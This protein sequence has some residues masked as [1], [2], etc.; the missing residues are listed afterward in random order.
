MVKFTPQTGAFMLPV[1][2]FIERCAS[3]SDAAAVICGPAS[4]VV[5]EWVVWVPVLLFIVD[6]FLKRSYP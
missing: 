5:V 1:F 4:N 2:H 6:R 3:H